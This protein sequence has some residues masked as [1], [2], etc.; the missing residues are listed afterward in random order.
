MA[1]DTLVAGRESGA[2]SGVAGKA[3]GTPPSP[4]VSV[5]RRVTG[6]VVADVHEDDLK[7]DAARYTNCS[8]EQQNAVL[9][10]DEEPLSYF[11]IP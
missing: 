1:G 5:V 9:D 2:G 3:D 11:L 6:R 8:R 7:L 10:V 4:R